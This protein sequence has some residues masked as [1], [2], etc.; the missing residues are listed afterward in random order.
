MP[1]VFPEQWDASLDSLA[2]VHQQLSTQDAS[3]ADK[4]GQRLT[5]AKQA[6]LVPQHS[7]ILHRHAIR[8]LVQQAADSIDSTA[9]TVKQVMNTSMQ[10]VLMRPEPQISLLIDLM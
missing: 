6:L 3:A 4:F 8:L 7:Q 2:S 9:D 5:D 1:A 10:H